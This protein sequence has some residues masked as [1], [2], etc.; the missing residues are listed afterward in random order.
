MIRLNFAVFVLVISACLESCAPQVRFKNSYIINYADYGETR[1]TMTQGTVKWDVL[2]IKNG[3]A[4]DYKS[5]PLVGGAYVNRF[6]E[7]YTWD[8]YTSSDEISFPNMRFL[9]FSKYTIELNASTNQVGLTDGTGS[10]GY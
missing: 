2:E 8:G 3:S 6:I 1:H 7:S 10:L 4:T 5:L 9:H